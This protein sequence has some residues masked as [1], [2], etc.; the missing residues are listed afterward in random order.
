[1]EGL[2]GEEFAVKVTVRAR[3]YNNGQKIWTADLHVV[4][5]G[6]EVV[7]RFRLT[8]PA[9]IASRS[10]AERWGWDVP[11]IMVDPSDARAT[12]QTLSVPPER[13]GWD[14]IAMPREGDAVLMARGARPC[15]VGIWIEPDPEAGILHSV[16]HSGVIFTPPARL[17]GIGYRVVGYYR[18]PA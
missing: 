17:A 18:R 6:E 8:C 2:S 7:D 10:G 16:E 13:L 12:R 11:P 4:P 1:M 9:N 3:S 5:L 14:A 15:H